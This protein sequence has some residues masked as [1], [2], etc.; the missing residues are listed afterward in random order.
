MGSPQREGNNTVIA[1]FHKDLSQQHRRKNLR[2][3][4]FT[5][6]LTMIQG[7]DGK[8]MDW[9]S[10]GDIEM[11]RRGIEEGR[12]GRIFGQRNGVAKGREVSGWASG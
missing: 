11:N 2:W 4:D 6:S 8:V 3:E 5:E 9:G 1:T 7:R 10:D 12:I